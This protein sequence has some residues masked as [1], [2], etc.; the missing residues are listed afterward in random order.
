M[1]AFAII[2]PTK[3]I[4][5][6]TIM[7]EIL[8][9]KKIKTAET[10]KAEHEYDP[11]SI[12]LLEG[13]DAV[14]K[15]PGMYIGSTNLEGLHH[16]VW[17]IIDNS[18]DEAV[19][20]FGKKITVIL[21]KDGSCSI[22]DEGRGIPVGIN[23]QTGM[24][25]VEL[26]FTTLH[27]G[28]KFD[29]SNYK[30]SGGLH[31]VGTSV[32]NALSEWLTCRVYRE[33]KIHEIAFSRGPKTQDLTVVG[34]TSKHG[35]LVRFKPDPKIFPNTKLSFDK[36]ATR[37]EERSFLCPGIRFILKDEVANNVKEFYS[38]HGL[39]DYVSHL[40]KDKEP[41]GEQVVISEYYGK[42]K[43]DIAMQW[44]LR[45][46]DRDRIFSYAN[47]VKTSDGGTHLQGFKASLTKTLNDWAQTN[48][49]IKAK[50]SIDGGDIQEG[51]TAIVSLLIP[52]QYLEFE[53]QTK[54]KLGSPMAK[55]AVTSLMTK[56][57]TY[58][59]ND[60]KAFGVELVKKCN[61]AKDAREAARKAR[62]TARGLK[63]KNKNEVSVSDKLAAAQSKDYKENELFIVEG[64]S[65]G[66]SAKTGRDRLHQ[67]IL[68][69]RGKPLNT[70]NATLQRVYD[71]AECATMIATI[72]AGVG[73]DFKVDNSH[74]GKIIIMT[75]ADDDGAHI[76]T[77]LLTFF[78]TF[79]K[80]LIDNGMVYIAQ[81]PLY[82]VYKKSDPSKHIY[83]W[84]DEE[85]EAA[86]NKL[87]AGCGVNRYKGLGEMNADQL[88][89]TTMNKKTRVLQRVVIESPVEVEK[90]FSILMGD[91]AKPRWEWIQKN[92]SFVPED[93][94]Y[95]KEMKGE[96]N[97]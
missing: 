80:P 60:H 87:G 32:T 46:Y 74:Y 36:I 94:D 54:S 92:V 29:D 40:C 71:N 97:G 15:R 22:E 4:W 6:F 56:E 62:E 1:S 96:K 38:E 69:L 55:E 90:Q 61:A 63:N 11:D 86:K 39:S 64:D 67:A 2:K 52:E 77:L 26:T 82:R 93:N 81:P 73:D 42:I 53:G 9:E 14:R 27:S 48:E 57:F 88:A 78:Y 84:T 50:D 5:H 19:N 20:G 76:Q 24:P 21:H 33:G 66:G 10:T 91:D 58:F 31:G 45:D 75:D 13:L 85:R 70:E 23:K 12:Q 16:L 68:P 7:E 18:V 47:D 41:L 89:D 37:I 44:C 35:T 83:C 17:E 28:G 51:L 59:L 79:M 65:A 30:T 3:H 43:V 95:I 8:E 49:I 25:A 34:T 72:G